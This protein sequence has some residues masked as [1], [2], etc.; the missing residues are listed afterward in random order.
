MCE[1]RYN[2]VFVK[3][4]FARQ[5][6]EF[7]ICIVVFQTD[8]TGRIIDMDSMIVIMRMMICQCR[9]PSMHLLFCQEWS[10]SSSSIVM[11][12][13]SIVIVIVIVSSSRP[14]IGRW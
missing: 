7:V 11:D 2:A 4:V 14:A 12:L 9:P 5:Y 8:G 10:S 1:L 6:T 13:W 3:G